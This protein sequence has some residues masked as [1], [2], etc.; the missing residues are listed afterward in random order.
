LKDLSYNGMIH[1]FGNDLDG[2][3]SRVI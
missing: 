1:F 3:I 2:A